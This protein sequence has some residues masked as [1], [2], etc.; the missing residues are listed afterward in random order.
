MCAVHVETEHVCV[1]AFGQAAVHHGVTAATAR[2]WLGRFLTTGEAGLADASSR[3]T[4]LPRAIASARALLSV[5]LRRRRMT[6]SRI[7]AGV[8]VSESTVSRVL[9]RA[10]LP[11][12]SDLEVAEPVVL[13]EYDNPGDLPHIETKRLGR[14]ER[15]SH[16]VTANRRDSVEGAGWEMLF[17]AIDD[18][19]RIA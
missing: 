10:G 2:K 9:A 15:P 3:P 7:A 14:I 12:L 1:L 13:H 11:R 16:R 17:V 6:Q 5:E 4:G 19:A 18:H 8:G